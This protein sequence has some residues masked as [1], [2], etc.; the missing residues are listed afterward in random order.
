MSHL[1]NVTVSGKNTS[2]V[3]RGLSPGTPYSFRVLA[4]NLVGISQP[5]NGVGI[6]TAEEGLY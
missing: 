4:K 2:A 5:S 1:P 3:V 6:T